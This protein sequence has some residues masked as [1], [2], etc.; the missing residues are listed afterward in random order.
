MTAP[1][2]GS[3]PRHQLY[4]LDELRNRNWTERAIMKF[5]GGPD[6]SR[7]N[8]HY[9]RAGA[10]KFWLKQRVHHVESTKEFVVWQ[11]RTERTKAAARK[12]ASRW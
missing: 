7:P 1:Q 3:H 10:M 9:N 11:A 2:A 5:L 6:D 8:P 4:S 12:R